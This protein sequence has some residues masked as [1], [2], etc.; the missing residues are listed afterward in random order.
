MRRFLLTVAAM[1]FAGAVNAG[2]ICYGPAGAGSA[3]PDAGT[4][5]T[6]PTAGVGTMNQLAG[7]GWQIVRLTPVSVGD[8]D[9]AAQLVIRRPAETIFANGFDP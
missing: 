7:L 2:E 1:L 5:F 3:P 6:C 9:T 8:G 4:V